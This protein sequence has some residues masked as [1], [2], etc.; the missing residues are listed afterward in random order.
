MDFTLVARH[1]ASITAAATGVRRIQTA[2][3]VKNRNA[4]TP[5]QE[6]ARE[7]GSRPARAQGRP[8]RAKKVSPTA[9]HAGDDVRESHIR[10][11][12]YYL[13]LERNGHPA[14]PLSDWLRAEH[15]LAADGDDSSSASRS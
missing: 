4:T 12:A 3:T 15:E 2:M 13:S 10:V 1:G 9:Q 7:P 8:T 6:P 5:R 11:R 14:D